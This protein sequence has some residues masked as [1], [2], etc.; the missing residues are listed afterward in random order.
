MVQDLDYEG[1]LLRAV[2]ELDDDSVV[3]RY[4]GEFTHYTVD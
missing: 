1:E 3:Q 4:I 2:P